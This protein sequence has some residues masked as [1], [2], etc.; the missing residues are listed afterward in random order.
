MNVEEC[1][2]ELRKI[3][4]DLT[5]MGAC[6]LLARDMRGKFWNKTKGSKPGSLVRL[7]S[8]LLK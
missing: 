4:P 3:H 6:L 5:P 8:K 2:I 7:N 1:R